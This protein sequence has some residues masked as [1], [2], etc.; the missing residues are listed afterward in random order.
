MGQL[1]TAVRAYAL[2][3]HS[4]TVVAERTDALMHEVAED[5]MATILLVALDVEACA[6]TIVSAGHP[7]PI[8]LG[9]GGARLPDMELALPRSVSGRTRVR[10]LDHVARDGERWCSSTRILIDR[11]DLAIDEGLRR[12]IAAAEANRDADPEEPAD[13]SWG[14]WCRAT[15]RTTSPCSPSATPTAPGDLRLRI[16]AEPD[17]L[18]EM[19][20]RLARWLDAAGVPA[21]VQGDVVLA[22]RRRPR[23]ASVTRTVRRRPG[24]AGSGDLERRGP[25]RRPRPR[26]LAASS[27]SQARPFRDRGMHGIGR[28]RPGRLGHGGSDASTGPNEGRSVSRLADLAV[29]EQD[30]AV[31]AASPARSTCRTRR[32]SS[33]P[34]STRSRTRPRDGRR[35]D[36][37]SYLDSAGIRMLGE[38]AERLRWREQRLAVVAPEVA[39]P[40]RPHD[41][42]C[43]GRGR[44]R[45]LVRRG[46]AN[47]RR[48]GLT[49]P[50]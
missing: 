22:S 41:G 15:S 39:G 11:H 18:S 2:E 8:A 32:R 44:V 3:G 20:R 33:V 31:V 26:P 6:A 48:R 12:L 38:M 10:R 14:R 4:P 29:E 21:D 42:R 37:V 17:A 25:R 46:A 49:R 50:W 13:R 27:R 40:R 43:P 36:G 24:R 7:P 5:E 28:D 35:P 34:C 47:G 9:P 1:R 30:G 45:G 23:T 19:R 16:P